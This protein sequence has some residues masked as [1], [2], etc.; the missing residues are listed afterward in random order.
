MA[1][2]KIK[3]LELLSGIKAHTLRIWEKR[4]GILTPERTATQI[5]TYNDDELKTLLN[6]AFLYKNGFKI[7]HIASL[8]YKSLL[9]QVQELSVEEENDS[10]ID[11]LIIALL[12]I[13]EELFASTF[14]HLIEKNSLIDIY[15]NYIIPFLEKLGHLWMVGTVNPAQ[16]HFVSNLI[17]QKII[18]AIDKLPHPAEDATKIVLFLPEH[19]WHELT[20]LIYNHYLRSKGFRTIYLGQALPFSCLKETFDKINPSYI[21][22]SW[23]TAVDNEHLLR[24]SKMLSEIYTGNI[25]FSGR[26]C[27]EIADKLPKNC[28]VIRSLND[29]NSIK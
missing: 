2:Y 7:S 13:N 8:P 6:I 28:M 23:I 17:R 15:T 29:L 14:D 10:V 9:R 24:Y 3:D 26:Q 12:D 11:Q 1:E 18:S 25:F 27:L 4:Y 19:D 16:E 22:S 21:I 20:L 5:R